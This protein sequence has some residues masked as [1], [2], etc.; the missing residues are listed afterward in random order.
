MTYPTPYTEV[1]SVVDDLLTRVKAVLG[2]NLV[3]LYLHGSLALGAFV[4]NRSDIDVVIL[5]ADV[6][7][8]KESSDLKEMH[9]QIEAR[10]LP[11]TPELEVA[12]V[13]VKNLQQDFAGAFP[14]F[15]GGEV[16]RLEKYLIERHVLR[17]HGVVVAGPDPKMLVVPI[18]PDEL[19]QAV[20]L[21]FQHHWVPMLR[22]T[23]EL[24][25]PGYQVYAVL[26]M[27]RIL[28]TLEH[29]TIVS[30]SAAAAWAQQILPE[31]MSGLIQRALKWRNGQLFDYLNET[32]DLIRYVLEHQR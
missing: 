26:T 4:P 31:P 24:Q 15:Y 22:D 28:Y 21:E 8:D 32:T 5:T 11:S 10:R 17:E 7:S 13:P 25:H 1:N 19:K 3:G 6:I 20:I 9:A 2:S 14:H 29:K 18:L 12:Y 23:K 16:L 27:C 30:K